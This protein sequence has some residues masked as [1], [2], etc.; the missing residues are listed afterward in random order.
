MKRN[1]KLLHN[2]AYTILG[3]GALTVG[4]VFI[5]LTSLPGLAAG[6]AFTPHDNERKLIGVSD[7]DIYLPIV[8][9]KTYWGTI[10]VLVSGDESTAAS[11]E[12][13][14]KAFEVNT[15]H[16][17]IYEAVDDFEDTLGDRVLYGEA[18][19]VAIFPQLYMLED[20]VQGGHTLDLNDW[21]DLAYLQGQ[22]AQ[23][24]L[25]MAT[26]EGE[27]AGVWY[28]VGSLKS[29][30]WF[31]KQ[32]FIAEGYL[33]PTTWTELL[34]LSDQIVID[35]RT[36]WCLGIESTG[37]TGWVGTDWVEDI[38]LRTTSPENYDKWTT[39]ELKFVSPEVENAFSLMGDIWFED[40]YV[41]GGRE[42]I[43]TTFFGDAIQPMFNDPPDCWLHRQANFIPY[44]FPDGVEIGDEV[45][46]FYLPPI[47]TQYGDPALIAGDVAGAFNDRPEVHHYVQYLTT[48]ESVRYW[49][50]RGEAIS[51]HKD[52]SLDWYP[53]QDRGYAEIVMNADTIRFDGSDLMP[54][55]VG[56]DAFWD[57]IV[58]YVNGVDLNTVLA[59]IDSAWP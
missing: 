18:P 7:T 31:P 9:N 36:P 38:M 15:G 33:I 30:V 6:P 16:N 29:L 23:S 58:D 34:A 3:I 39:G 20:F 42:A 48:G 22:Y 10:T 59:N 32:A 50:E 53:T 56:S 52:A 45:D 2:I 1:Q 12:Q 21:F 55:E 35:G 17:V 28:K 51:P 27:M 11:Y 40:D 49:V 24:W 26:N 57:G 8:L 47:D 46:Y 44:F 19:D 4:L 25:D 14:T 37:A 41:L 5:I 43:T 13:A 54:D